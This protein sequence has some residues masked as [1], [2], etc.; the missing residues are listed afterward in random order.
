MILHESPAMAKGCCS[1]S[2][3]RPVIGITADLQDGT[4]RLSP[5]YWNAIWAAGGT[6]VVLPP[7]VE[8]VESL[9]GACQAVVLSGGDDPIMEAWSR[10]THPQARRVE[11][12]RQAFDLAIHAAAVSAGLPMLGICLGMQFMGLEAGG[13]LDQHLP[14][15]S[16]TASIHAEGRRH[17]VSG[18]LGSGTVHS[19]HHQAMRDPGTLTVVAEA[20]DGVIEAVSDPTARFRIGVQWHPERSGEGPLGGGLFLGLVEAAQ[21]HTHATS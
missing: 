14:D 12:A 17:E 18:S 15:S 21:D 3:T 1:V 9:I 6:P 20:P 5:A 10:P 2:Q 8:A 16:P 13:D 7:V 4:V 11:P 19:R